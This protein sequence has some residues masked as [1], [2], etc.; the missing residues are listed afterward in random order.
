MYVYLCVY[1]QFDLMVYINKYCQHI[2]L[3]LQLFKIRNVTSTLSDCSQL[4][5]DGKLTMKLFDL[6]LFENHDSF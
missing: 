6:F 1:V 2:Y 3:Y 5:P 4:F